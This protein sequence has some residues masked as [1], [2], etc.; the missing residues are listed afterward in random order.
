MT[1]LFDEQPEFHQ[2]IPC[3]ACDDILKTAAFYVDML[4][5]SL[6]WMWG[7][8]PSDAGIRRGNVDLF[9]VNRPDLV[10]GAEGSEVVIVVR[11]IDALHDEHI[12]RGAEMITPLASITWNRRE[13]SVR[14]PYGY[15]LRFTEIAED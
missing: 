10:P 9:L 7:D 11:N 1:A 8:P 14:A 3:L 6:I 2:A 5:F 13:Y 12:A 15:R 4:G